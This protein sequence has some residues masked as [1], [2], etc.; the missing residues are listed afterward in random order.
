MKLLTFYLTIIPDIF[1]PANNAVLNHEVQK[2]IS[3][4]NLLTQSKGSINI[5]I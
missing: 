4:G 3:S 1:R 2:L 5:S